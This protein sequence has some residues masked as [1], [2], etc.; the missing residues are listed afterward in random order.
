MSSQITTHLPE[1]LWAL[2]M[3]F[4]HPREL[5]RASLCGHLQMSARAA[6]ELRGRC[7]P[8]VRRVW[9]SDDNFNNSAT[10]CD[11]SPSGHRVISA[12]DDLVLAW[13]TPT[14]K[15]LLKLKQTSPVLCCRYS[16]AGRHIL[17]GGNDSTATLLDALSGAVVMTF[18]GHT[19]PVASVAFSPS[20]CG[21]Q[22]VATASFDETVRVWPLRGG[23]AVAELPTGARTVAL[24]PESGCRVVSGEQSRIMVWD[25]SLQRLE[26]TLECNQSSVMSVQLSPCGNQVLSGEFDRTAKIWDLRSG[27][28]EMTL[29]GH[30]HGVNEAV[31]ALP[32]PRRVVTASSD[33]TL[34]VWD[35]RAGAAVA[36]LRGHKDEVKCCAARGQA[37]V[38]GSVNQTLATWLLPP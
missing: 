4:L 7:C 33:H 5:A 26:A 32:D 12:H 27:Q 34:R 37:A 8:W 17:C 25:W 3:R 24:G 19:Q 1:E 22:F 2:L 20:T 35:L 36:E 21:L 18:L 9:Y 14:G 38:S 15:Q 31:F 28:C 11:F 13:D 30:T 23:P 10:S 6:E 29:S 16:P